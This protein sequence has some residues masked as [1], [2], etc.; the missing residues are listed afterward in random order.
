MYAGV[1]CILELLSCLVEETQKQS[2][3]EGGCT[4]RTEYNVNA[5]V[6]FASKCLQILLK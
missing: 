2:S 4:V 1:C 3:G 5:F 6:P